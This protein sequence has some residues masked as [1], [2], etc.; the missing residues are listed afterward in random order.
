LA[1]Y[2]GT[3]LTVTDINRLEQAARVSMGGFQDLEAAA[4]PSLH[5]SQP[6]FRF[7]I[8]ALIAIIILVAASRL[9]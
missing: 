6:S 8:L 2:G 9:I 3:A 5:A 1:H 7:A 4:K